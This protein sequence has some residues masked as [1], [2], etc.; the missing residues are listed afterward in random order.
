[1]KKTLKMIV[2][3]KKSPSPDEIDDEEQA[4]ASEL[5]EGQESPEGAQSADSGDM[6]AQA[7]GN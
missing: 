6:Y 5:A 3:K 1:M 2:L 4:E 7:G